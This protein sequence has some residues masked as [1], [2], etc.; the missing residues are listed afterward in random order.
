MYDAVVLPRNGGRRCL[1]IYF[2]SEKKERKSDADFLYALSWLWII[3]SGTIC[4]QQNMGSGD[5]SLALSLYPFRWFLS[6]PICTSV[7]RKQILLYVVNI[8]SMKR[9]NGHRHFR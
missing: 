4:G 1:V 7:Y 6:D 2:D 3:A 5:F 8:W 9:V